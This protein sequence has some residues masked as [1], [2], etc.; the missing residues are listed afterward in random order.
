MT[1]ETQPLPCAACRT[2]ILTRTAIDMY[3]T[4]AALRPGGEFATEEEAYSAAVAHIGGYVRKLEDDGDNV[5]YTLSNA[6]RADT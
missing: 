2:T 5:Q 4:C 1:A 3:S 6:W